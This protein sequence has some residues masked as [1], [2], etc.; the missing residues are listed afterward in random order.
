MDSITFL[1]SLQQHLASFDDVLRW[2]S[3]H[4]YSSYYLIIAVVLY[5]SGFAATGA[6]LGCAVLFSTLIVGSCRQFFASPRPYWDHPHLFNGLSEKAWGMPSGHTQNAVVY[7][8]LS[9]FSLRTKLFLA[10]C[11]LMIVCIAVSRMYLGVH[12]PAQILAGFCVGIIFLL[13]WIKFEDKA[14]N[15][16]QTTPWSI[17]LT[18]VF[19][20][21]ALPLMTTIVLREFAGLGSGNGEPLT[22]KRL[23]FYSGLLQGAGISL[24]LAFACRTITEH[25]FSFILL[26]TRTL[27][28]LLSVLA[29]WQY[30]YFLPGFIQHPTLI[31][32]WFWLLGVFLSFWACLL[33]PAIH[34]QLSK[35]KIMQN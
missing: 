24:L 1:T 20:V 18:I 32:L 16:L 12:F 35:T 6:R 14:L 10:F 22:Y 29:L 15:L 34:F 26:L 27:P 30:K 9:A 8:G 3:L 7:W 31:C 19:L 5:W 33:W 21:T 4:T 11:L 13:I 28:G 25:R 23:L 2:L 17:R